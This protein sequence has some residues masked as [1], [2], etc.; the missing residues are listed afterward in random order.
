[1]ICGAILGGVLGSG[2][3]GPSGWSLL[4]CT[5]IGAAVGWMDGLALGMLLGMLWGGCMEFLLA[6]KPDAELRS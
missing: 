1:M 5:F 6:D 3:I 2:R 4:A